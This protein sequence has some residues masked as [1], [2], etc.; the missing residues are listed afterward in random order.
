MDWTQTITLGTAII[1]Y[2]TGISIF[3]YRLNEKTINEWR[4]EHKQQMN[5]NEDHWRD[6]FKY[7]N[8]RIDS[9]KKP[10]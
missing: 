4:E 5:R 2:M 10:K 9:S 8:D 7:M 6:M 1:A 3:L